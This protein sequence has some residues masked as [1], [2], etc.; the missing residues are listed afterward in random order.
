MKNNFKLKASFGL[1]L[2]LSTLL[3]A[4]NL[5]NYIKKYEPIHY[6]ILK[7]N[8]IDIIKDLDR[9]KRHNFEDRVSTFSLE[10]LT[11]YKAK[12]LCQ[13]NEGIFL[14]NRY[15]ATCVSSDG[16]FGNGSER[17]GM[18]FNPDG[19]GTVLSPDYLQPG[20]PFEFFSVGFNGSS[21][22]NN[23]RNGGE[24]VL[25]Q[26][27]IPIVS[28][29]ALN[30]TSN[31]HGGAIIKSKIDNLEITQE[32]TLDP[33]SREIII[34]VELYNRGKSAIEKLFYARGIDPDQDRPTTYNTFNLRGGS[35]A[36][37]TVA[38]E[39]LVQATGLK[40]K[41]R[42]IGLY[43]VD[44]IKHNTCVSTDWITNPMDIYFCD[45][46]LPSSLSDNTINISFYL[47]TLKSGEKK[48]LLF[49]YL[50]ENKKSIAMS[51]PLPIKK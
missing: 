11:V 32:Y 45:A 51:M 22:T 9:E 44:P 8:G 27:N 49:K 20:T 34:R 13:R 40:N 38:P 29:Q 50:F 10:E 23:N 21:Y 36:N 19:T 25:P 15:I 14:E 47:E 33:N 30:R 12:E 48:M 43:S 1:S 28:L 18:T 37:L 26:D 17:L 5:E 46:N 6:N 3:Y 4:D 42:T 2:L 24:V 39:N 16:T 35:F 7:E 31:I 41:L